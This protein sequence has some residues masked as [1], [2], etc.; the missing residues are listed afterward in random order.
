MTSHP[1]TLL[2]LAIHRSDGWWREVARHSGFERVRVVTDRRGRGDR[3]VIDDFYRASNAR[4]AERHIFDRLSEEQVDDAIARCRV[5]RWLPRD[6]A[7][8]MVLAM[9]DVMDALLEQEAPVAIATWPIDC[10]LGHVL[11]LMAVKRDIPFFELTASVAPHASMLMHAGQLYLRD[12]EPEPALIEETVRA[13]ADPLFLPA[14]VDAEVR[15]TRWRWLKTFAYFRLRALAFRFKARME[16][17]PLNIHYLD[18]QTWLGHKPKLSDIRFLSLLDRNWRRKLEAV[19][20]EKRMFIALQL[21]PEASID[22]WIS[23][24][25]LIQHD[26]L[27]VATA[28]AFS[29]AGYTIFIKD[30]PLQFGF[31]RCDLIDRLRAIEN[32]VFVP[33]EVSGNE[34]LGHVG[35]TFTPTGTLGLQAA[36]LGLKSITTAPYYH[37]P[38]DFIVLSGDTDIA[39]LPAMVSAMPPCR[40]PAAR[41]RRVIAHLLQGSFPGDF[42][43]FRRFDPARPDPSV[44]ELGRR[45]G[46]EIALHVRARAAV[47]A[48]PA[49]RAS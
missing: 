46:E 26:D 34:L 5:L 23:D 45:T 9:A 24:L 6:R 29:R 37:T 11:S 8:R 47:K 35:V 38:G 49:S 43:S 40:N 36:L 30:H 16:R 10:Y 39:E 44:A 3:H 17:D 22:Y 20:R 7:A 21:F 1:G 19:E 18:A 25:R 32:V 31:R 14:Y 4:A 41:Q 15:Y 28:A 48:Y 12:G 42:M 2:V 13:I 27:I 33:Y